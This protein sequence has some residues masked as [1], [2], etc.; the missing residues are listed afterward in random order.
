MAR[1][2]LLAL[3]VANAGA[4]VA[5]LPLCEPSAAVPLPWNP[6]VQVVADNESSHRLFLFR[7]SDQGAQAAGVLRLPVRVGDVEA[8]APLGDAL[9]VAG[10]FSR[11][12]RCEVRPR[13]R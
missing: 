2:P 11:N 12:A 8:L 10:S 13:R 4:T 7:A 6:A 9:V 1:A 3:L 5:P